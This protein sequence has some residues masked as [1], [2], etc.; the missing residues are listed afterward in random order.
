VYG[1]DEYFETFVVFSACHD[2]TFYDTLGHVLDPDEFQFN[3]SMWAMKAAHA[4]AAD[5]GHGPGNETLII[6]R[7]L[8]WSNQ[9]KI[10]RSVIDSVITLFEDAY[11]SEIEPAD[12]AEELIP[13]LQRRRQHEV[14]KEIIDAHGKHQQERLKTAVLNL[15]KVDRLGKVDQSAGTT[16]G[17]GSFEEIEHFN[18]LDRFPTGIDDLDLVI[19]GAPRATLSMW[20]GGSGDGKSMALSFQGAVGVISGLNVAYATLELPVPYVLA[21]TKAALTGIPINDIL[22]GSQ[23]ARDAILEMQDDIGFFVVKEFAPDVSTVNDIKQW[24]DTVEQRS[25][26]QL[27][28]LIVDYMDRLAG[29][30]RKTKKEGTYALGLEVA[31]GL[32]N[33]GVEKNYWVWTAA[34]ATRQTQ[35]KRLELS[36]VADSMHK[37]RIADIALTLNVTERDAGDTDVSIFVAKHRTGRSRMLVGPM[38]TEFAV[39]RIAPSSILGEPVDDIYSGM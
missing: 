10:R 12:I 21:R 14:V 32:R 15:Q 35:K 19:G 30:R 4:I 18:N 23:E 36:D 33:L 26:R 1:L 20:I 11:E 7:L 8:R 37:I 27:D 31:Q 17:V 6:Q 9:G 5:I 24:T 2:R 28:M 16:L 25:G 39:G 3:G 38:P 29:A 34:Q 22:E 13:L